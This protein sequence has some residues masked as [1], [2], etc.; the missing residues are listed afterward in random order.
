MKLRVWKKCGADYWYCATDKPLN[1]NI[2]GGAS[3]VDAYNN[4]VKLY[5]TFYN[6]H[7]LA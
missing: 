1:T 6:I 7:T 3:P 5:G 2:T 4:W